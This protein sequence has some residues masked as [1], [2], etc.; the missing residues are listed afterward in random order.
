MRIE[1]MSS[2]LEFNERRA[3]ALESAVVYK[4]SSGD[5]VVTAASPTPAVPVPAQRDARPPQSVTGGVQ[6]GAPGEGPGQ[7][8]RRRRRRRGRRNGPPAAMVMG[9]GS[10]QGSGDAA[11]TAQSHTDVSETPAAQPHASV[12]QESSGDAAPQPPP[13]SEPESQ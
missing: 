6:E 5:I 13:G 1:S 11:G 8:S 4:P 7:R 10:S 3:R 12:P 9:G 2:R